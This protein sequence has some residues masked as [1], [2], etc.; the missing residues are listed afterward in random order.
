MPRHT[1]HEPDWIA[2]QA[3]RSANSERP[4]AEPR[5]AE[6]LS[7]DDLAVALVYRIL[8]RQR[9]DLLAEQ[10]RA[11]EGHDPEGVH[12]MRVTIRRAR[13]VCR[14][15]RTLL[16]ARPV[17]KLDAELRWLAGVLG[18]V[19]DLDVQRAQLCRD[20]QML[21]PQVAKDLAEYRTHL[22]A[23]RQQAQQELRTTLAGPRYGRL[24]NS[25]RQFV[26]QGRPRNRAARTTTIRSAAAAFVDRRLKKV[27]RHG[28]RLT[29]H[30]ELP[31]YHALRI[32]CKRL[33]YLC[34]FL[35][36]VYGDSLTPLGKPLRRLQ[37]LLGQIQDACV[38]QT[39]LRV[40]LRQDRES[41]PSRHLQ[42]AAG[43]LI[44]VHVAAT[45]SRRKT[46]HAFWDR[47]AAKGL[48]R[49]LRKVL[50]RR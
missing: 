21:S 10:P 25:L 4:S 23:E 19:R 12:Q 2:P 18:S 13:A 11:A 17:R 43:K 6:T 30:S 38:A 33:R 49:R 41:P 8:D 16:P 37:E 44:D 31:A 20:L 45:R 40:F 7:P 50:A 47:F 29:R 9:Q 27:L 46:F 24:V 39:R 14:A 42:K 36:P 15:F 35:A 34:E 28:K 3:F 5:A 22:E 26:S 32:Q 48:R 1:Q